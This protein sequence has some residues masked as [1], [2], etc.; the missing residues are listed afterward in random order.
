[1]DYNA[2][3]PFEIKPE[4]GLY[5]TKHETKK[6][7]EDYESFRNLSVVQIL[8]MKRKRVKRE[9]RKPKKNEVQ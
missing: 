2:D 5:D 9:S 7:L 3:I 1:M 4:S 8:Q 6:D